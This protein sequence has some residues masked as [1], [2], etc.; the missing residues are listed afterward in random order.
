MKVFNLGSLNM[1]RV[2][3]VDHIARP[4]ETIASHSLQ[5]FAGGKGANQSVA[6]AR[7]GAQVVHI[8][9]VGADGVWLREKLA[10]EGIAVEQIA[11]DE[12]P[13]GQAIIQVARDGQNAIVLLGGANQ[14]VTPREIATSL[15]SA[16]HGDWFLTQNETSSVATAITLAKQHGL[17]V[18]FNP[19]PC[20]DST[21]RLPLEH[22]DL[23]CLNETE[24]RMLTGHVDNEAI[25]AAL[26]QRMPHGEIVLT[27]GP[28][29]VLYHGAGQRLHV[30]APA[31]EAVDTTSAGDT[32]LGYYLASRLHNLDVHASLIRACRAAALCVTRRGAMDSIPRW[33]EVD[34]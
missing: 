21:A 1:D 13:T 19:A 7:A 2:F 9:R 11:L 26:S 14:C 18:A 6:L 30:P 5:T 31:V 33:A 22:V 15:A 4:G 28:H 20:D 17:R 29:G 12:G 32:F 23:L 24:G 16:A 8:G 25:V 10:A 27:L 3:G 34:G